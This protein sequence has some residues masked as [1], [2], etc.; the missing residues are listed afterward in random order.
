[1]LPVV[2]AFSTIAVLPSPWLC[3]AVVSPAPFA[4][5]LLISPRMYDS[6]ERFEP[7]LSVGA[8]VAVAPSP[9]A[10]ATA[11]A[12]RNGVRKTLI[13]NDLERIGYAKPRMS[14]SCK[15]RAS[16]T[17]LTVR[18]RWHESGLTLVRCCYVYIGP[19]SANSSARDTWYPRAGNAR[20]PAVIQCVNDR[21]TI[22]AH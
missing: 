5:C 7:T 10:T 16:S 15:N 4:D 8:A 14:G 17:A 21:P 6:V 19:V 22:D 12:I 1:M 18:S 13:G 2:S 3:A 9:Q 20:L 11:T